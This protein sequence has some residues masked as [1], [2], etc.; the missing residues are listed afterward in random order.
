[1]K[2]NASYAFGNNAIGAGA[3]GGYRNDPVTLLV[4][5]AAD[6]NPSPYNVV[7]NDTFVE[8]DASS[9]NVQ[10]ILMA[11]SQ[12]LGQRKRIKRSD[13]TYASG[14][15]V[16]LV[17]ADGSLIE[18]LASISLTAQNAIIELQSDG[19]EWQV[20]DGGNSA[21]W[22]SAS[23][24]AAIAPGASPYTYTALAAGNVVVTGGTVSN[25]QLKRGATTIVVDTAT[26]AVVPVSAGDQVIT[27]YS[28]VPT[29]SFVP[30]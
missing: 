17:T 15:S 8:V 3:G 19:T 20:I 9:Q 21:A 7:N 28:V 1:M 5:A 30:R 13:A 26:N 16:Q 25:V 22:G 2:V 29:M 27:T 11:A 6:A 12:T 24:I 4:A 10:I 14:N 18:G 23:A